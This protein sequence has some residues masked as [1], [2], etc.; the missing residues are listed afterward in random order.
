MV[1]H[2]LIDLFSL[3]DEGFEDLAEAVLRANEHTLDVK[4]SGRGADAGVDLLV[5]TQFSDG[6]ALHQ[7]RWLVQ[8]K[9]TRQTGKSIGPKDFGNDFSLVDRVAQH[10]ADG[11]LL[12]I[13]TRPSTGLQTLFDGLNG[14]RCPYLIWDHTRLIKE[15]INNELVIQR[16]FPEYY[17]YTKGLIREEKLAEWVIQY[18]GAIFEEAKAALDEIAGPLPR[19]R[20]E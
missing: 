7:F 16:F 3:T 9:H 8:C 11:Y 19:V 18:D 5:T 2:P 14:N 17:E 1:R 15:I 6:V 20:D 10:E 4:R 12:I 13:N